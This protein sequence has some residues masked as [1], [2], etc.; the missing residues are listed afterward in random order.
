[1]F[2]H[3]INIFTKAAPFILNAGKFL[4]DVGTKVIKVI[5]E[6]KIPKEVLD[7]AFNLTSLFGS[8]ISSKTNDDIK[9]MNTYDSEKSTIDDIH[10]TSVILD[11]IRYELKD[12]ISDV[13]KFFS[14]SV[15]DIYDSIENFII[16]D[17][18]SYGINV[19]IEELR[20][21]FDK[22]INDFSNSFSRH[23]NSSISLNNYQFTLILGI[24]DSK[25]RS[26][27]INSYISKIINEY[28]DK[29]LENLDFITNTT[30][31]SIDKK[32]NYIIKE[33]LHV[34]EFI[35]SELDSNKNL[36]D[37][38]I[39]KKLEKYSQNEKAINDCLKV[40]Y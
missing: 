30:I 25:K 10:N 8:K 36:T 20:Y 4:L 35:K 9:N 15:I 27:E 31:D 26:E 12:K 3:L 1:M 6:I 11:N 38:E 19:N 13:E 34:I 39:N 17:I 23:I 40:L 32:I 21:Y 18:N 2:G 24:N 16:N 22:L 29:Y 28:L 33:H 14:N 5:K 7:I 37:N